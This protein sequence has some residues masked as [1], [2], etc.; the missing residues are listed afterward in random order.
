M[1][2]HPKRASVGPGELA[3]VKVDLM[4]DSRKDDGGLKGAQY[5]PAILG[6]VGALVWVFGCGPLRPQPTTPEGVTREFAAA[7]SE[8]DLSRAYELMSAGYRGRVHFDRF[9]EQL[10]GNP[11]ETIAL[12]NELGQVRRATGENGVLYYGDDKPLRLEPS[13]RSWKI[14]TDLAN[15]YDQSTPRATLRSFVYAL[16]RRRYNLVMR[17]IPTVDKA[18]VTP[19]QIAKEWSGDNR[20]AIE[21]LLSGLRDNLNAPIEETG[22]VAIMPYGQRLCMQFRREQGVWKIETLE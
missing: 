3:W 11:E 6:I 15:F 7:L 10:E 1:T 8:N 21:R 9:K 2:T 19:E 16:D 4:D 14:V 20:Q 5:N 22:D 12:S 17:F 18:G 13:G